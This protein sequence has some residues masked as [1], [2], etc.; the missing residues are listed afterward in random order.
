MLDY[1]FTEPKLSLYHYPLQIDR[2]EIKFLLFSQEKSQEI[3]KKTFNLKKRLSIQNT[4]LFHLLLLCN[5]LVLKYTN[6][7]KH[8]PPGNWRIS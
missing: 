5:N 7:K 8:F 4:G 2:T 6:A 1:K 3:I